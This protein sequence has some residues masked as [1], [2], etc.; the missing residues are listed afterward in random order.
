MKVF[1]SY[2]REN[3]QQAI[4]L[5]ADLDDLGHDVW[6]DRDLTGGQAWWGRILGAIRDCEVLVLALSPDSIASP[7]C[8]REWSYA[9]AVQRALLPVLVADGVSDELLP[10]ELAQIQYTDYRTADKAA[11]KRLQKALGALPPAQALPDPLPAPPQAPIS[12]LVG[13]REAVEDPR[14]LSFDEQSALAIKLKQALREAKKPEDIVGLLRTLRARRD[15][16]A[17]VADEIDELVAR[18]HRKSGSDGDAGSAGVRT[19]IPAAV[20]PTGDP[21]LRGIVELVARV[22]ACLGPGGRPVLVPRGSDE[23]LITTRAIEVLRAAASADPVAGFG[24]RLV[25]GAALGV[26]DA[27]GSG[28]ATTALIAETMYRTGLEALRGAAPAARVI[29]EIESTAAAC[30]DELGRLARPCPVGPML[31]HVAERSARDPVGATLFEA[32]QKVGIAGAVVIEESAAGTAELAVFKGRRFDRGFL[33]PEFVTDAVRGLAVLERAYVLLYRQPI[34]ALHDLLPVLEQVAK[35]GRPLL[36][37]A[38]DVEGEALATLVVNK[39]KGVLG[40]CA[41]KAPGFGDRREMILDDLA[42]LTGATV[43]ASEGTIPLE[44]ATLADLG[45]ARRIEVDAQHTTIIEGAGRVADIEA[46]VK[47]VRVQIEEATS[48]YDREKLQERVDALAAGIAVVSV[49]AATT[50]LRAEKIGRLEVASR[51]V[52]AALDGGVTAGA[53]QALLRAALAVRQRGAAG[54]G[55]EVVLQACLEPLR[56]LALNAG[57]EPAQVFETVT[58]RPE[59]E[60]G[61][62]PATGE[63]GDLVELGVLDGALAV[64]RALESAASVCVKLLWASLTP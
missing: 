34:A 26:H 43:L 51:A 8:R 41:V 45:Q 3:T 17:V 57:A 64:R 49:G 28:G 13:L 30:A 5:A 1:L 48:D 21:Q 62:D 52:E 14:V 20:P 10:A 15:L 46:R 7:A 12:Y 54:A 31:K 53:G 38:E 61:F 37:V 19:P 27:Y 40:S 29:K 50:A 9:S 42:I 47:Q 63:Y 4:A 58:A 60:F 23:P 39:V 6:I 2:G 33:S 32:K 22:R 24:A 25:Q 44:K 18:P 36:V 16:L 35:T 59:P 55:A 56:Q 11:L